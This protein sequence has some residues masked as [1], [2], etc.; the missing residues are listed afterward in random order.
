MGLSLETIYVYCLRKQYYTGIY[1]TTFFVGEALEWIYD[2]CWF[3]RVTMDT[4]FIGDWSLERAGSSDS[5]LP[6]SLSF[7]WDS[8]D[9]VSG[10][11]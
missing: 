7:F 1:I 3:D 6:H 5:I 9:F 2:R 11:S 10:T 8:F 4:R